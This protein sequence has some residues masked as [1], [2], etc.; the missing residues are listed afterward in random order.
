MSLCTF[1]IIFNFILP[2]PTKNFYELK[3]FFYFSKLDTGYSNG[4]LDQFL[5]PFNIR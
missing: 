4:N 1:N 2:L 3:V 5:K